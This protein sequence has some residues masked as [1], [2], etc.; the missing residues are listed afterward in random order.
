[1]SLLNILA[2]GFVQYLLWAIVLSESL[3]HRVWSLA[4]SFLLV[5]IITLY[6]YPI[7][8]YNTAPLL[9]LTLLDFVLC[10]ALSPAQLLLRSSTYSERKA[11]DIIFP[12][13][14]S[15]SNS[16]CIQEDLVAEFVFRILAAARR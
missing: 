8:I 7:S 2:I 1:M 16:G 9:V 4:L 12:E 10:L 3:F 13:M 15:S 5:L 14:M 6:S 11:L